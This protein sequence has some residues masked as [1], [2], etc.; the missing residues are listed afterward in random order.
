MSKRSPTTNRRSPDALEKRPVWLW[1]AAYWVALAFAYQPVWHGSLIWDDDGHLTPVALRSIAGLWRIWFEPGA[2]QQYYPVTHTAFWAMQRVWGDATLGYHL[3][4]ILL[5][6]A[7]AFLLLVILRRLRVPA[8][9]LA[10]AIFALH[11]I[12]VESVAWMSELKNTLSGVLYFSAALAYLRFDVTRHARLYLLATV[13][14]VLALF[15]KTV[16]ATL[17]ASLLVVIW[18]Q[19]GGLDWRRDVRPLA[20]WFASSTAAGLLTVWM[21]RTFIGA[22][23][24]EFHLSALERGLVA[25]RAIWFYAAT[26]VWPA[27]LAFV[28]PRWS[29]DSAAWWQYV[30]PAA[31]LVVTGALWAGRRRTRAPLA[32]WLLFCGALFP[33]LGFVAAFPF[34]YSFVADHFA[35][36]AIAPA[37]AVVA[38]VAAMVEA[39]AT[40]PARS[41][42]IL[43]LAVVCSVLGLLTFRESRAYADADTLYRETIARNPACWLCYNNLGIDEQRGGALTNAESD[44]RRAVQLDPGAAEPHQNLAIV[45]Q[46][47]GR[48]AAALPEAEAA[49]A[50]QT[51]NPQARDVLAT[52]LAALGRTDDAIVQYREAIAADPRRAESH[53]HLAAALVADG[54]PAEAA[55]EF[56]A[57]AAIDPGDSQVHAA[58]GDADRRAGRLEDALGEYRQALATDPTSAELHNSAGVT[59]DDLGRKSEAVAELRESVR[60]KPGVGRTHD[61]LG[62]ALAASGQQTDAAHEFEEAIRLQS[63]YAP[64]HRNLGSLWMALGR[65]A[66][67]ATEFREAVRIDPASAESH[68]NLAVALTALGRREEAIAELREALR[69]KPDYP[70]AQTNLAKLRGR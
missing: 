49:V 60:L 48:A 7:S 57:A 25:G 55:A 34:R 12:Q 1:L 43:G 46:M 54:R 13:L 15:S 65:V 4:N 59:L 38:A 56:R 2:T 14:F 23:G 70:L 36:L 16:T 66:E 37:A 24:A 5:H 69:L 6:G 33:S 35:Y 61:N 31:A 22:R 27:H 8:A 26:V 19:R 58:L 45:L 11:P 17:P 51:W 67:A 20:P 28:Y 39:R 10:A 9:A 53:A 3:V 42:A 40:K 41:A 52:T 68:N 30:Y 64:A 32:A 44:Y 47:T 21:E 50:I 62:H 29:I 18:W 63:D